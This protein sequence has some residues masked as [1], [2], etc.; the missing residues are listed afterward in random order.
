MT[1]R[2]TYNVISYGP[3]LGGVG[4]D[5]SHAGEVVAVFLSSFYVRDPSGDMMCVSC[6]TLDDGPIMLRVRFPVRFDLAALPC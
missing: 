4:S 1:T 6:Q 3:G 5:S 2:R